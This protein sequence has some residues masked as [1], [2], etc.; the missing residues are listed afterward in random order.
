MPAK[1]LMSFLSILASM[2][3]QNKK[4]EE[5]LYKSQTHIVVVQRGRRA[6]VLHNR[7]QCQPTLSRVEFGLVGSCWIWAPVLQL[8]I[9]K[10]W[11]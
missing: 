8:K 5:I 9:G 2:Q 11:F 7:P 10:S 6:A 3:I 1:M 4:E